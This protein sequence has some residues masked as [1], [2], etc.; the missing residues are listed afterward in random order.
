M[1]EGDNNR[2]PQKLELHTNWHSLSPAPEKL[3]ILILIS[4]QT[5]GDLELCDGAW[6]RL[7]FKEHLEAG[8]VLW[9][10]AGEGQDPWMSN[11]PPPL[12]MHF[13]TSF[14]VFHK[15]DLLVFRKG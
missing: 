11:P 7:Q 3:C 14:Q 10:G 13:Q 12:P 5:G 15:I 6:R 1:C 4:C 2:V 9:Q 8:S